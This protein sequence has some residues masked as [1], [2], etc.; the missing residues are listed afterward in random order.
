MNRPR[1]S[2][3]KSQQGAA[4][5]LLVI[6]V[7][8][9]ILFLMNGPLSTEL[10]EQLSRAELI[11]Q[12]YL[13]DVAQRLESW[14]DRNAAT[15]DSSSTYAIA[16]AALWSQLGIDP[17]VNLRLG[18]S[19]RQTGA[20]VAYRR[21]VIWLQRATPDTS[22][23]TASTGAFT[24]AA[25]VPFRV[26]DGEKMQVLKLDQT[27]NGMKRF[28]FLLERRFQAKYEADPLRSLSVNHFRPVSGTCSTTLDDMPCINT[29]LN[30]PVAANFPLLVGVDPATLT[31]AWGAAFEVSNQEDSRTTTPPYT[32]AIRSTTPWG[33]TVLVNAVQPLN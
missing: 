33:S 10:E 28:A 13:D 17:K 7:G 14:Y 29:Y 5:L 4:G 6:L 25:G 1:S 11:E 9:A 21:F 18:I 23:F 22:T 26:I 20:Q 2:L 12:Q 30:A 24:P 15:V 3:A 19:D 16:P 8:A 27:L 32:M 31:T